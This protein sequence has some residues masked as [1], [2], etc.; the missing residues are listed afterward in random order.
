MD[1]ASGSFIDNF[2]GAKN[3]TLFCEV[4]LE[5]EMVKTEWFLRTEDDIQSNRQPGSLLGDKRFIVTGDVVVSG[6]VDVSLNTNMTIVEM[7]AE[8]DGAVMF[9]GGGDVNFLGNFSLRAYSES[10][11]RVGGRAIIY[12]I[13]HSTSCIILW[14]MVCLSLPI[15][16][17]DCCEKVLA[18]CSVPTYSLYL[19]SSKC[20]IFTAR[21]NT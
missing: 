13:M 17:V 5:S 6:G 1:P 19:Y 4:V 10:M 16:Y 14:D 7:T 8:L 15:F 3:I 21:Y 12:I 11:Y 9:C 18:I 20:A 2:V